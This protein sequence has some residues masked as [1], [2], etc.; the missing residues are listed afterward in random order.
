MGLEYSF[1]EVLNALNIDLRSISTR[2][3]PKS[4]VSV[5]TIMASSP[6]VVES[7]LYMLK[8]IDGVHKARIAEQQVN[9]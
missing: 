8:Q 1:R 7:V 4:V 5:I 9:K 6:N 2:Y 3:E